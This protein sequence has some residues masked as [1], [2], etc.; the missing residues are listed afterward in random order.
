MSLNT[1]NNYGFIE[2][3][4]TNKELQP[5]RDEIDE[6]QADFD[7]H[8]PQQWNT[9]LS[10]NLKREFALPKSLK[11]AETLILPQVEEY[12]E[13]FNFLKD[14][15]LTRQEVDF[16]LN[17]LWVN[18]QAKNEFNPLHNHDGF[19]SFVIYTKVP[20]KMRDE[21]D[22]SP[23]INSN[24]NVPGH[25]QFSYTGILGGIS[26]HYVPVDESYENTMMLFPSKLMHCVY[27]FFT[28]DEYRISVA[29][30]IYCTRKNSATK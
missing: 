17:S 4:F 21:L 2:H 13:F 19:M 11:H 25:F 24:N 7:M 15:F 23:G 10:G 22:A 27:P 5:I 1:F 8:M 18:F 9:R 3:V 16:S 29:G 12:V 14:S 30:N 28:S 26:N 6:I 20:F